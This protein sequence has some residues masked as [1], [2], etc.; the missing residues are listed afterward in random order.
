MLLITPW[1]KD[2]KVTHDWGNNVIIV[3]GKGI[4]KTI[5]VNKKL[6]LAKY[7]FVMT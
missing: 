5:S 1:L 3:Q 2:A 4:V 7:L 6:G